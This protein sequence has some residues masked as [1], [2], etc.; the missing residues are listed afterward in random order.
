MVLKYNYANG[1]KVGDLLFVERVKSQNGDVLANFK[2]SCGNIFTCRIR[3][4]RNLITRSC[5]C[6]TRKLLSISGTKHG[7]SS[8]NESS[9]EY[10]TWMAMKRRINDKKHQNYERYKQ[11]CIGIC[12]EW[13]DFSVFIKDMGLKPSIY[14]TLDRKDNDKGYYKENCRWAT[15]KQQQRNRSNTAFAEY[16]GETKSIAEWAELTGI[17]L[18]TLYNRIIASKWDVN[19]AF[20]TPS[21]NKKIA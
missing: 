4:V 2:C 9:P 7:Y 14:H 10:V 18:H 19:R 21:K 15:K 3:S 13:S 16:N 11:L 8:H 1:D 6:M 5:G 17:A 20:T 12:E